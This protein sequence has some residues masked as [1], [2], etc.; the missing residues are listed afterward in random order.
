MNSEKPQ[1]SAWTSEAQSPPSKWMRE[2]KVR[3]CGRNLWDKYPITMS[4]FE[5][6]RLQGDAHFCLALHGIRELRRG[7]Y[8]GPFY[9]WVSN[10]YFLEG[11]NCHTRKLLGKWWTFLTI[12]HWHDPFGINVLGFQ[13]KGEEKHAAQGSNGDRQPTISPSPPKTKHA[14]LL[15][16][17]THM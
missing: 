11:Q 12:T 9:S 4:E 14:N 6:N 10:F 13:R 5:V 17:I 8:S 1:H 16:H 3:V 2:E 7:H 15:P